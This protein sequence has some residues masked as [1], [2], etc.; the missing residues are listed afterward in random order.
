MHGLLNLLANIIVFGLVLWLV[1]TF[2][3]MPMAIKSLLNV[4]VLIILVLFVLQFFGV[5]QTII[6]M[7]KILK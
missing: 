5:I 6:P 4:V 1:N 7:Y 3:P 2:I